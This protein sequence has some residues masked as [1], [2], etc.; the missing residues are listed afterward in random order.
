MSVTP[1]YQVFTRFFLDKA[2]VP[3]Y[4]QMD[5]SFKPIIRIRRAFTV[6]PWLII[7]AS[8]LWAYTAPGPALSADLNPALHF[9]NT[10][11]DLGEVAEGAIVSHEFVVTNTGP[12]VLKIVSVEP[13]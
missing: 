7:L 4:S 10:D 1:F 11:F 6:K 2:W 3:E 12:G 8:F 13:G 5:D 9:S